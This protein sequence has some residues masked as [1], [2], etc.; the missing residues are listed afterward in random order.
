M[1]NADRAKDRYLRRKAKREEKKNVFK[2]QYDNFDNVADPDK[3]LDATDKAQNSIRWKTSPQRYE[4]RLTYNIIKTSEDLYNDA[5]I[6]KGFITFTLIERGKVRHITSVHFGERVPQKALCQNILVPILSRT[7]IYDN[8]A[9]LKNK[10]GSFATDQLV[11]DLENYYHKYKTNEGYVLL[12]DLSNFFGSIPHDELKRRLA[13]EIDDIHVLRLAFDFIDS[14][15]GE[16]GLGL[17][18]ETCQIEAVFYPNPVDHFIKDQLQTEGYGRYMDDSYL[19]DQS[20]EVLEYKRDL[21]V[22]KY[23][24]QGLKVN[25]KKTKI[26]KLDSPEFKFLKNRMK[27]DENGKVVILPAKESVVRMRRKLK[28]LKVMYD[29][30]DISFDQVNSAYQSWRGYM[31]RKNAYKIITDMDKVFKEEFVIPERARKNMENTKK[32]LA[33]HPMS[34]RQQKRAKQRERLKRKQELAQN[35]VPT[36]VSEDNSVDKVLEEKFE[37]GSKMTQTIG[38]GTRAYQRQKKKKGRTRIA[39]Q[40]REQQPDSRMNFEDVVKLKEEVEHQKKVKEEI[41]LKHLEEVHDNKRKTKSS[42]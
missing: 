34:K 12:I 13:A 20:K 26:V 17:G 18:S 22:D 37:D 30:G 35:G 40:L 39:Q 8:G 5:D 42:K 14:F 33:E 9:C 3:L 10:G 36:L 7:L 23:A 25:L 19:I 15:P 27:L 16:F 24:E 29:E 2:E 32:Q 38:R 31:G 11:E 28:K 21:I 41:V 4:M 1:S 6:R